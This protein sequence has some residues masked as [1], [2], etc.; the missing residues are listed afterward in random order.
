MYSLSFL[1]DGHLLASL[2]KDGVLII[3]R[4]ETWVEV[5][6]MGLKGD[7]YTLCN[8]A[9][10]PTLSV[11]ATAGESMSDID[12][13]DID[14]SLLCGVNIGA[15]T[16]QYINA[17]VVLVGDSGVGKS[18]LGIRLAE[19]QFRMTDSTH[20]AQFWHLPAQ[21]LTDLPANIQADLTLWDL[22][23]QP[24][25]RLIHQLFLDDADAALLL[26]DSS[27]PSDPFRGVPYWSKVLKAHAPAHAVKFLVS[28]RCDVSPTTADRHEVNRVL[29]RCGLDEYFKTSAKQGEG[30]ESLFQRLL[31]DIAW[32]RLPR[33]SRPRLF[34]VVREFLLDRK[35][36]GKPLL[37]MDEIRQAARERFTEREPTQEEL[38]TVVRLLQSR[39]L[40]YRLQ[41][42]PDLTLVLLKPELVNQY[43]SSII[44]AARN[45]PLGIG[46][47]PKQDVLTGNL[48]FSGFSRL[49]QDH[50]A[51]VLEATVEL[52]IRRELC[53]RE[54]GHL[55]FP[56]QIN[57]TRLPP[58][59]EHPQ[60]A[61]AYRF[62]GSI[63]IIYASLV[64]R[65]SYTDYFHRE[66][67]WKYAVEFSRDGSR[68]GF[69][70]RQIEE[71]T[72]ELEIY[73]HSGVSEFDRGTFIRFVTDHLRAKGI[74]IEEQI[75][76]LCPKCS[77][78][79]TNRNAIESRLQNGLLDI[80]CQFCATAIRIPAGVEE[81]YRRDPLLDEKQQ[82]LTENVAKRTAAEVKQLWAD[83]RQTVAT[84]PRE[85]RTKAESRRIDILHLSDLHL[86]DD[87]L[88][89]VYRAQL[90]ADLIKELGIRRLGYL[91]V[92]G[93]LA[94]HATA[95][96]YRAAYTMIDDLTKRFGLDPSRVVVVP[97]NHDVNW[98]LSKRAYPFVHRDDLPSPLPV[99]RHIPA[100]E[101]GALLRDER[102]YR[103][104]FAPFN[105]HFFRLTYTGQNYPPDYEAQILWSDDREDRILFLG[106]NS[107]WQLD[108]HFHDRAS[109]NMQALARALDRLH[110]KNYDGWLK[111][112]VWHH[113]V[114]GKQMMN[115]EFLQ[116]LA[117]HGFQ[118]CLHGH[119]H[120]AVDGFHKY[121]DRRGIRIVGA[122]TFGAPAKEQVIGVPLQYNLLS[123]EP[124]TGEITVHTRKKEKPDGAWSA[125]ARW[126]DRNNP[127]SWYRFRVPHYR[128][129]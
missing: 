25:Y 81:L 102:R 65:L 45:H 10:H 52:L 117:V 48:P 103:E 123:F 43:G 125:D 56:S 15:P 39:G 63:E 53:F 72:G 59:E 47:V 98:A 115:D 82:Q 68:L 12:V 96:E 54:M 61:V 55:V 70:M 35:E 88:A 33:T 20:G 8:L 26:V 89:G 58:V 14:F 87:S 105:A 11:M 116:L 93:D 119:L 30:I 36:A 29:D 74:D 79:V 51:L 6:R 126:G 4:A 111:I 5:V 92:S 7:D 128:T 84:K 17:K 13:W 71:G 27:D 3:W 95:E 85:T 97:G 38:D 19:H 49:P 37:A 2:G 44:Q 99:D 83:Q 129:R 127:K 104:R 77:R 23:G 16:V 114:T 1:N 75:R 67:Q 21:R 100:G 90:E 28:A 106:L 94:N 57:V 101:V 41:P 120:E 86:E 32:N 24:D 91:V 64:V 113:P 73:F 42:R 121:D 40:V 31:S 62:S 122:G 110:E 69:V 46:A 18:G 108:H 34:Q 124:R 109:I 22:A 9:T 76:V 107:C 80:P 118:V 112:A 50:E 60:T 78:E 66:D